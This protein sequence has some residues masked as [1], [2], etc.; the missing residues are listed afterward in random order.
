[1]DDLAY[2]KSEAI[3]HANPNPSVSNRWNISYSELIVTPECKKRK[4]SKLKFE[5][6]PTITQYINFIVNYENL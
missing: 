3:T 1:L 5:L 2:P 4:V 6:T